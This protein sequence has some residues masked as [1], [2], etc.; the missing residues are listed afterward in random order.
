MLYDNALIARVY[1]DAYRATGDKLYR[2]IAEET[3]DFIVREMHDP[4]GAFDTTLDADSEGVEGKYY[5]WSLDEF[6]HVLGND[7]ETLARY[8]DVT[9]HGNWEETNILHVAQEAGDNLRPTIDTA[10]TKLYAAREKRVRPARDEKIL[11]DWNG[12]MLR[13]FAD[14]AAYLG[15]DD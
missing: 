3:L 10:R 6:R 11:T 4:S 2:R 9:T 7:A 5:V 13:A 1:V 8:F 14:A 15:R 12:L